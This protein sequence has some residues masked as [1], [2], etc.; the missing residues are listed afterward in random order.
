MRV[1]SE[2]KYKLTGDILITEYWVDIT[3]IQ[4][5]FPHFIIPRGDLCIGI[6]PGSRHMGVSII[7]NPYIGFEACAIEI[8]FPT[9]RNVISRLQNIDLTIKY[10][11]RIY[12]KNG[13]LD[14]S[15]TTIEG[16][17]YAKTYGQTN[18]A[19]ARTAAAISMLAYKSVVQI[20]PPSSLNL[21]VFGNGR[22]NGKIVWKDVMKP[23]AADSLEF[24][25][26]GGLINLGEFA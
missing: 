19:E 15:I 7:P 2:R 1:S 25:L 20:I 12:A 17:S 4:E 23:N 21:K 9:S 26:Y 8:L 3:T 10:I 13:Y 16:A 18:I 24:A 11:M 6:D 14:N 22:T 5:E